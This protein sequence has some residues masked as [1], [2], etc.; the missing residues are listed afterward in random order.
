[1]LI[2]RVF[3]S[4]TLSHSERPHLLAPIISPFAL[5]NR[6]AFCF[7]ELF[8]SVG[9]LKKASLAFD[10]TGKSKG[11][12]EI[13][14]VRKNDSMLAI[15]KYKDVALDGRPM[16]MEVVAPPTLEM[17]MGSRLTNLK[18][19]AT[20]S[21]GHQQGGQQRRGRGGRRQN[22][23]KPKTAEDLDAE[24]SSYM[25]GDVAMAE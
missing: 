22:R 21:N 20:A 7:Q 24:M 18:P 1:M 14:F 19:S 4:V 6:F 23:P 9:P 13:E 25:G 2:N 3:P 15:K 17:T 5:T 11:T 12:A 16:R 10:A 8:G